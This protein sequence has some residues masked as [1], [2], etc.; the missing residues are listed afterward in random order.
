MTRSHIRDVEIHRLRNTHHPLLTILITTP[1]PR[2]R[3]LSRRQGNRVTPGV[4][5]FR[6]PVRRSIAEDAVRLVEFVAIRIKVTA[7]CLVY[8][9][10]LAVSPAPAGCVIGFLADAIAV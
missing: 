5:H 3:S 7:V 9:V 1:T 4:V 8:F 2:S 6:F 10:E